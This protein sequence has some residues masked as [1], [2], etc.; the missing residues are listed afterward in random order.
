MELRFDGRFLNQF[1]HTRND[2]AKLIHDNNLRVIMDQNRMDADETYFFARQLEYV[3]KKS[4]D[5][6]YPEFLGSWICPVSNE[7]DTGSENVTYQQFEGV[8]Q[9]SVIDNEAKDYK[10]VEIRAREFTQPARTLG[11][12]I[13]WNLQE[14]RA[15]ALKAK[16]GNTQAGKGATERKTDWA[17]KAIREKEELIIAQGDSQFGLIGF[18]NNTNLYEMTS[19]ASGDDKIFT[20][21]Q[22]TK[23]NWLVKDADK[24]IRDFNK[25]VNY[26][27]TQTHGVHKVN[28]VIMTVGYHAHLNTI[29]IPN[30]N[31]SVLS[32][33]QSVHPDVEVVGYPRINL[34]AARTGNTLN[35]D[36]ILAY[37]RDANILTQE[38]P[39]TLEVLPPL[40]VGHGA[41]ESALRERHAGCMIYYP[42]ACVRVKLSR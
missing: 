4:A 29:R 34:A 6:L 28:T 12:S 17:I 8:G 37:Q 27:P 40:Q 31:T 21:G 33:L 39:Q 20:D 41:F 19:A 16:N 36:W 3:K 14:L 42:K 26:I 23:A 30:T 13:K 5:T 11:V 35:E 18:Y 32:Y 7:A 2:A 25:I 9:A 38:I 22:G 1:K 24:I 15:A 10:N